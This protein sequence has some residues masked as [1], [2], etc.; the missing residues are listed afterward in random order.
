MLDRG[1]VVLAFDSYDNGL[2]DVYDIGWI[3]NNEFM[4]WKEYLQMLKFVDSTR[5]GVSGHSWGGFRAI[6]AIISSAGY[7]TRKDVLLNMLH[8]EFDAEVTEADIVSQDADQVAKKTLTEYQLGVYEARKVEITEQYNQRISAAVIKGAP[9]YVEDL[10]DLSPIEVEVAGVPVIRALQANLSFDLAKNDEFVGIP[11]SEPGMLSF[12]GASGESVENDMVYSVSQSGTGKTL[13]KLGDIHS[14]SSEMETS[15]NEFS[16]RHF[17]EIRGYHAQV[18]VSD[19]SVN[20]LA[21]FFSLCFEYNNGE[22]SGTTDS[23]DN[24]E[25]HLWVFRVILSSI[26]FIALLA[27]ILP[28]ANILLT[29]DIF[30]SLLREPRKPSETKKN[31]INWV[32]II[33]GTVLPILLCGIVTKKALPLSWL[34]TIESNNGGA[35]WAITM[36]LLTA[37]IMAA[38]W[39]MYDRKHTSEKFR[40]YYSLNVDAKNIGKMIL[41]VFIVVGIFIGIVNLMYVVFPGI[42]IAFLLFVQLYFKPLTALQYYAWI[43]YTV[44]F[45]PFWLIG[46]IQ[47]DAC[48]MYDMKESKNMWT[49]IA[50]N[51]GIWLIFIAAYWCIHGI[52]GPMIL[53]LDSMPAG[54]LSGIPISIFVGRFIGRKLYLKTGSSVP[55]AI[56]ASMIF[57]L[58]LVFGENVFAPGMSATAMW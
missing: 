30:D 8:D 10:Y 4:L 48:R 41:F 58:L 24:G 2:S 56:I 51:S 38:K 46:G 3:N 7:Y 13:G 20:N 50:I 57:T 42:N 1:F 54:V 52:F 43:L 28:V 23:I 6:N 25:N 32:F 18:V 45:L 27:L 47:F 12:F 55:G 17:H 15:I 26:C 16:I 39:L 37:V 44:Y 33:F 19:K 5:I 40:D 53:G 29:A 34:A 21:D 49:M 14:I 35:F 36:A 11:S 22:L 31:T 9:P